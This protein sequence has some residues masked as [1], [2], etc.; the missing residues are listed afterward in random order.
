[1]IAANFD[2]KRADRRGERSAPAPS[3][4]PAD[5]FERDYA[6]LQRGAAFFGAGLHAPDRPALRE[7]C[8]GRLRARVIGNGL[9]ELDRILNLFIDSALERRGQPACPDQRNTANKLNAYRATLGLPNPDDA[10]MRALGRSRECLFHCGGRVIRGD[11]AGE[12]FLTLG[13]PE[14]PGRNAPLRRVAIGQELDVQ[15]ADLADVG[16][17]YARLGF[18]LGAPLFEQPAELPLR[19]YG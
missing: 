9:R 13:W 5:D 19:R 16:V 1:M 2:R 18:E 14:T 6:A 8:G 11:R 7:A 17:F 15:Q 12:P 4:C 10:R 3:P